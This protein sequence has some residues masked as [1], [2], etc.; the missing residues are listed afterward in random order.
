MKIALRIRRHSSQFQSLS[1]TKSSSETIQN[2]PYHAYC[3]YNKIWQI[4]KRFAG[5]FRQA[6]AL[7][8]GGVSNCVYYLSTTYVAHSAAL[9]LKKVAIFSEN[10]HFSKN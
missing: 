7:N 4:L 8:L 10:Q 5:S 2:L 1:A 6:Q 3:I 9:P